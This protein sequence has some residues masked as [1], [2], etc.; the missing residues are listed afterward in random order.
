MER[1]DMAGYKLI[2]TT[3][4]LC[5][6]CL[7]VIDAQVIEKDGKVYICKACETHGY[8][9][10]IHP[11]GNLSY[12]REMKRLFKGHLPNACPD[13][14]VINIISRCDLNCPFCFAR[15]NEYEMKEPS[16]REIK[17]KIS[18]FSGS[19]VYL[20]GGEPTLREDLFDIVKEIKKAG[21]KVV[22]F[23]NG[24]KLLDIEFAYRLKKS[25]L[26][27][28]ILQFDT[29]DEGQCE[30]LRG[31]RLVEI[32]LKAIEHLKQAR[33]PLYLFA[34]LA[35]GINTDQVKKLIGFTAKNSR[36]IKILNLNPVW[37]MGRVGKHGPMNMSEIFQ[38]VE[39][40][41]NINTEDFID[42]TAFS[43]YIFSICRQL[44]GKGGNKHPWC[45][46]R[47]Y[48]FPDGERLDVFG[49]VIDIKE[50]NQY[51]RRIND[52]LQKTQGF[53]K[54]KLLL[55]LPYYF[56]IKEFFSRKEF[57]RLVFRGIKCLFS[58]MLSYG[59]LSF[60]DFEA[61]S[62]IVGTFHTALNVDLG[63]VDTCNLYSD[64]PDGDNR[65]SCLRQISLMKEF[66][67]G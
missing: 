16:V 33:I 19:I 36:F 1:E 25:G 56:L 4:S 29:F 38:E 27:L 60:M 55:F 23:T 28:V 66:K 48:V 49:R 41:S 30:A 63:L 9:E 47:C 46:M 35:K 31:E 67:N 45:E 52:R 17:E 7:R 26:D 43:Y 22:L 51:L 59:K 21:Y 15:A 5:P 44:T 11:L 10:A 37:E 8:F 65:S 6:E 13:G 3:R 24:R 32:K 14:L 57:R 12:Y 39:K 62:I 58:S 18:G 50:L 42:G 54:I 2:N 40:N 64:F 34:M 53:K 20:S 61:V